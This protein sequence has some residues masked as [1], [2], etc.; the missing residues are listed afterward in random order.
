[1]YSDKDGTVH[2]E[3]EG[4]TGQNFQSMMYF[5]SSR[6]FLPFYSLGQGPVEFGKKHLDHQTWENLIKELERHFKWSENH[7]IFAV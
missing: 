3:F 5:K 7:V 6:I 4:V 1:M 2:N